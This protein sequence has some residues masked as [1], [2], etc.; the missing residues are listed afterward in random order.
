V[1]DI[2]EQKLEL[3][4]KL[5]ADI[6]V[7]GKHQSLAE[8]GWCYISICNDYLLYRSALCSQ[9]YVFSDPF[10]N[11]NEKFFLQFLGR[12]MVMA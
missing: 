3:A 4:K 1:T 11:R 10:N 7:N 9:R 2:I 8:V 12:R 6:L 5:G